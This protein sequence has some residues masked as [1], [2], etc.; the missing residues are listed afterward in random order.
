MI[1]AEQH[2]MDADTVIALACE[3][4][5]E[6]TKHEKPIAVVLALDFFKSEPQDEYVFDSLYFPQYSRKH[7]FPLPKIWNEK[8]S[9]VFK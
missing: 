4:I 6:I 8:M 7:N 5:Y 2:C 3:T 9:K 1:Y